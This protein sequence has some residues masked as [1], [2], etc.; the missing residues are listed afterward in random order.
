M[1]VM[2]RVCR[3]R[4]PTRVKFAHRSATTAG[5]ARPTNAG[6]GAPRAL[7]T[8]FATR[9]I[10]SANARGPGAAIYAA[11]LVNGVGRMAC[12]RIVSRTALT[13]SA[14]TMVAGG[15]AGFVRPGMSVWT[16][17]ATAAPASALGGSVVTMV[18]EGLVGPA[19]SLTSATTPGPARGRATA[20]VSR[21]LWWRLR[22]SL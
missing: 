6:G 1:Q 19:R 2:K 20:R 8:L 10:G 12:A 15:P 22:G 11:R 7:K 16:A 5:A 18:A 17:P 21:G 14:G 13:K 9:P 3:T 4:Y